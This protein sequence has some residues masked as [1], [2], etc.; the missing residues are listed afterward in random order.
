MAYLKINMK[1]EGEEDMNVV[2]APYMRQAT[3]GLPKTTPIMFLP[4]SKIS[5][6]QIKAFVKSQG[7][8]PDDPASI[9]R[10]F[11]IYSE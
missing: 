6:S 8:N 7:L 3:Y 5:K 4:Y 11:L 9:M 2:F 1:L 10:V